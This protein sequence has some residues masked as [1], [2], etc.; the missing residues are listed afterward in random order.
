M[1]ACGQ[2]HE[3]EGLAY[4]GPCVADE[5]HDGPHQFTG[6][7]EGTVISVTIG[8]SGAWDRTRTRDAGADRILADVAKA[9]APRPG[10]N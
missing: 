8:D 5:D 4:L 10:S 3:A 9:L 6:P 2:P 1:A 7:I